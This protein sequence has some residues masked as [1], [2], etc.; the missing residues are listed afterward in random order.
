MLLAHNLLNGL[1]G[2]LPL[3][4]L[5]IGALYTEVNVTLLCMLANKAL[6]ARQRKHFEKDSIQK[7]EL[8]AHLAGVRWVDGKHVDDHVH[9][10]K[11]T[12]LRTTA[13]TQARTVNTITVTNLRRT[14][15]SGNKRQQEQ[16][17]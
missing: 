15:V 10:P 5:S 14:R 8:A 3:Q 17:K 9:D 4:H 11:S 7:G 16:A 13:C 6:A 2:E 12:A 1:V